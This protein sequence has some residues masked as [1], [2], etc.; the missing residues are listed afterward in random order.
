M[1][2]RGHGFDP[3]DV[4]EDRRGIASSIRD[5]M[6]R[7]GGTA[8]ITSSPADGTE[9]MLELRQRPMTRALSVFLV[10]DHGLFLSGVRAELDGVV[11]VVGT[12]TEV[13]DAID[14]IR[15]RSPMS[16]SSTC[17]CRTAAARR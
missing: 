4:P 15:G 7:H 11:D 5:R 16:C 13:R 2:D 17:T 8:T 9:V 6:V 12:S 1:R 14:S 3:E 10:D